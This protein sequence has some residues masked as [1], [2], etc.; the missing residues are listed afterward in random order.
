MIQ[1][2][3]ALRFIFAFFV[4]LSH[5]NYIIPEENRFWSSLYR[6]LFREGYVGVSFF[7]MLS[8]YILAYRYANSLTQKTFSFKIFL[9]RRLARIIPMYYLG[10]L[11]AL[12]LSYGEF[13]VGD[14]LFYF[15]KLLTNVLLFQSLIPIS[16]FYFSF[17]G[18]SWSVATELIFYLSFPVLMSFLLKKESLK[19]TILII[20]AAILIIATML[21]KTP[22]AYYWLYISPY[23]RLADFTMGICLFLTLQKKGSLISKNNASQWEFHAL[24]VFVIFLLLQA[25]VHANFKVGVFYWIPIAGII[26]VFATSGSQGKL[27]S[28][29]SHRIWQKLGHI[30]FSFYLLHDSVFKYYK[31]Y[32]LDK[33][34][35]IW[36]GLA[37]FLLL[38]TCIIM[39]YIT[40]TFVEEPTRK[41]VRKRFA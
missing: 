9:N 17:N 10:L 4:F 35:S 39:S 6:Y 2:L 36:T 34:P 41:Y 13:L 19:K 16:D 40:Y 21:L 26:G 12:P 7:F 38:L 27:S 32:L 24:G 14:R 29:L 15:K 3:N 20:T 11:V 30:S 33:I 23:L 18:V 1:S 22:N 37:I 5:L 31:I 25:H 28:F 8:G